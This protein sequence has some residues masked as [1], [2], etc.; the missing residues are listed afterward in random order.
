VAVERVS[1]GATGSAVIG[2]GLVA[3]SFQYY[4]SGDEA[5]R[6]TVECLTGARDVEI[7]WRLWREQDRQIVLTRDTFK[8]PSLGPSSTTRVYPLDAGALLNLR[9]ACGS[10][11]IAYGLV[12]IRAQIVRGAG[13]AENIIGTV[14][15]GFI[16]TQND[17]GWPGSPIE[18]QD[19]ASGFMSSETPAIS[20][21]G[22][23]WTVPTGQRWTPMCGQFTYVAGGVVANRYP[24]VQVLDSA[25]SQVFTD[26][27][28]VAVVAGNTVFVSFGAGVSRSAVTPSTV[29]TLC[30][31]NNVELTAG[32]KVF[33]S[34]VGQQL[35]DAIS[36]AALLIRTRVDG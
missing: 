19:Q 2:R 27:S 8:T 6:V 4:L 9:I 31:P 7:A 14:L 22:A 36:S 26:A 12:W 1:P 35:G 23:T 29:G 21:G 25:A 3:S 34:A 17:L 10:T 18:K 24:T 20:G 11:F 15:Q 32:C 13:A 28:E 33:A 30:Y 5:L 16:S